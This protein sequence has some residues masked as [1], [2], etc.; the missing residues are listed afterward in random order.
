M[1]DL[2]TVSW[3]FP[4]LP[5]HLDELCDRFESAWKAAISSGGA[6]PIPESFLSGVAEPEIPLLLRE[7]IGLEVGYRLRLGETPALEEYRQRFPGLPLDWLAHELSRCA[8]TL[9]RR[10]LRAK[11][12]PPS[13]KAPHSLRPKSAA[14]IATVLFNWPRNPMKYSAQAA[15]AHFGSAMRTSPKRPAA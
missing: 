3:T 4:P 14:R 9:S 1:N 8:E 13:K 7:L 10:I 11:P 2:P 12:T 6:K 15:A 5:E